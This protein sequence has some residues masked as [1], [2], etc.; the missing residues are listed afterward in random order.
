MEDEF[1]KQMFNMY[2]KAIEEKIRYKVR[3]ERNESQ[4]RNLNQENQFLKGEIAFKNAK[5]IELEDKLKINKK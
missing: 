3:I 2:E 4:L 5:I 1:L